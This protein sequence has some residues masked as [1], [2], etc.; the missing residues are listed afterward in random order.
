MNRRMS[1]PAEGTAKSKVSQYFECDKM[2]IVVSRA[3]KAI[4]VVAN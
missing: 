2:A 4:A 3:A 1:S